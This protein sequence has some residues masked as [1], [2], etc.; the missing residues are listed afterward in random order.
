[1]PDKNKTAIELKQNK[2]DPRMIKIAAVIL[3][4]MLAPTF[5]TTIVNVAVNTLASSLHSSVSIIQWVITGYLLT[6]SVAIPFSGWVV[7]R[8]GAKKMWIVSLALFLAGSLFSALSWNVGSL[9]VFRLL[10]GI[11]GGFLMTIGQT[12]IIQE[13]KGR[14][15]MQMMSVM[16]IPLLL[17]P[18]LGPVLGGLIVSYINWRWTFF[19]NIPI[20]LIALVLAIAVLPADRAVG[21]KYPL[22]IL[23]ILLLSPGFAILIYGLSQIS[24]ENGVLNPAVLIPLIIGL[25]LLCIY[26]VHALRAKISPVLDLRLFKSQY[27][28]ASSVL[29]FF[30]GLFMY[31]AMILLPLYYQQVR[32][33]S[34]L[35]T[36]LILISQGLGTLLTRSLAGRLAERIG[37]RIVV[38]GSV[39]IVAIGTLPFAFADANTSQI[40]LVLF[41]FIRGAGIGGVNIP[42]MATAYQGLQKEQVPHASIAIRIL[43]QVGGAFGSAILAIIVEQQISHKMQHFNPISNAYHTGF[44]WA[45]GF[46]LVAILPALFLPSHKLRNE[47]AAGII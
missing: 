2:L 3:I 27:F 46:T 8:F 19:V 11:G 13:S 34:I 22:D 18:I 35:D 24:K 30:S 37:T 20:C 12:L 4:G 44:W 1:M 25:V 43:Q 15:L 5:D 38:I 42:V 28:S 7:D 31:G 21:K 32:K 17:G 40:V 33:E 39:I 9:I 6:L 23:G 36:G 41:L 26:V 45:L 16:G 29:L 10:Q 47:D 14:N